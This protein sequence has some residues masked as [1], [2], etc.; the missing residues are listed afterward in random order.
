LYRDNSVF[1]GLTT[2]K[3]I[4]AA[5]MRNEINALMK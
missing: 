5:T 2:K 1:I 3:K 4:T